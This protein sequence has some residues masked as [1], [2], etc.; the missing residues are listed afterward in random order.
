MPQGQLEVSHHLQHP[1][2]LLGAQQAPAKGQLCGQC[3]VNGNS[4][5]MQQHLR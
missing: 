5:T 4:L 2:A 3:H 1:Q